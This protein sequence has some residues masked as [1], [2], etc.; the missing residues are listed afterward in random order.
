MY[1]FKSLHLLTTA[2][3]Q[4]HLSGIHSAVK[5]LGAR[6][7]ILVQYL[8]DVKKGTVFPYTPPALTYVGV[9]QQ[10]APAAMR[11][12]AS[13]CQRLPALDTASFQHEH[14]AEF[15]DSLL[16]AYLATVTKSAQTLN[17]VV[18]RFNVGFDRHSRRRGL[19]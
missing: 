1:D 8:A 13:L 5:M 18:D 11:Q 17:E 3:V 15:N 19:F 10:P 14:M 16:L 9:I 12:I 2:I 7:K 6:V 4:S